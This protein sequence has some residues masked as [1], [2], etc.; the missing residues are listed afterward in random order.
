[1]MAR[2]MAPSWRLRVDTSPVTMSS[3]LVYSLEIA[4]R[5]AGVVPRPKI[6]SNALRGSNSIGSGV[7]TVRN[8]I[9][10]L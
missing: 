5:S 9:V 4:S 2:S 3:R 6:F 7:D 8:E 10:L 1:M